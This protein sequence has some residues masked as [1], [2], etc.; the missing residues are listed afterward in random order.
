MD[1]TCYARWNGLAFKP[2]RAANMQVRGAFLGAPVGRGPEVGPA[3]EG[4]PAPGPT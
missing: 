2:D 4:V 3:A 1:Y